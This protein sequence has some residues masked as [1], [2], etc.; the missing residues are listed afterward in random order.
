MSHFLMAS[1]FDRLLAHIDAALR[2]S[3]TP[4]SKSA[5]D[6]MPTLTI[7]PHHVAADAHC[8]VCTDPFE[9]AAEAREMPCG[10]IYHH[11]CILPWL[12]LRNSC[13]VCRHHMPAAA[14][15]ADDDD[16]AATVG[17]TIWRL[18]GGGF[19]VGRFAGGATR[20]ELPLVFT[21]MDGDFNGG[22]GSPRRISWSSSRGG[23]RSSRRGVIGRMIHS[24]FSCFRHGD[25][26]DYSSRA[27]V[28]TRSSLRS[29]S[30][31]WRSEDEH[32]AAA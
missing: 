32:A 5:V 20:E 23:R 14:A 31:S 11:D 12:A 13:P 1:G 17:L 3:S 26:A 7:E 27:S 2:S 8:A 9:L 29:R 30:T 10:H 18:P 15:G 16:A 21:E 24:V 6:S 22:G 4:A 28:F 19:A 25:A